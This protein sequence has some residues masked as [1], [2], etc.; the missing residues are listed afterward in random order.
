MSYGMREGVRATCTSTVAYSTK[1]SLAIC[2]CRMFV[3][4]L[5][6]TRFVLLVAVVRLPGRRPPVALLLR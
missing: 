3:L 1:R 6:T 5:V 4:L 2:S